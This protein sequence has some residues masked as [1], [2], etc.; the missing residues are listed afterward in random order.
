MTLAGG[1]LDGAAGAPT[2][3]ARAQNGADGAEPR[4]APAHFNHCP[5]QKR[6]RE[7]RTIP[8]KQNYFFT[9]N[10]IPVTYLPMNKQVV[11]S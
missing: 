11:T 4:R 2:A 7:E 8:K 5:L 9:L 10:E 3:A 1:A 6:S